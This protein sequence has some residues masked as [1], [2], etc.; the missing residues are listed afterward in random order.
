MNYVRFSLLGV[1]AFLFGTSASYSGELSALAE[2][3]ELVHF[4]DSEYAGKPAKLQQLQP[5]DL[6]RIHQAEKDMLAHQAVLMR[7]VENKENGWNIFA[8]GLMRSKNPE[9]TA[10]FIR[11]VQQNL[12][13]KEA[14]GSRMEFGFGAKNGCEEMSNDLG[15]VLAFYLGSIGD[16]RAVPTLREA[17]K[18]GDS[19][20]RDSAY[21]ALF[22]LGEYSFEEILDKLGE[23][24]FWEDAGVTVT[25]PD[26]PSPNT[27]MA[28]IED[29]RSR[30]SERAIGLYDQI[31]G[32]FP[33]RSPEVARAHFSKILCYEDLKKHDL[34]LRQCEV[35][36]QKVKLQDY[37][38]RI[39][40]I[41]NRITKLAQQD[42]ADQ[43]ATAPESKS[44]GNEKPNP[45]S[46]V[47]PQ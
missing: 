3:A 10:F 34:A 41:R 26:G 36:L 43:P 6:E 46:E 15:S 38:K 11:L 18:Q 8:Y 14:D 2:A 4:F 21:R 39:P 37:T 47:R 23:L 20:V 7:A 9:V 42:G 5:E 31:I 22:R 19:A 35:A 28:I 1:V 25:N 40:K 29:V 27:V 13:L 33:A 17:V 44:E 16:K 30:D 45:E 12:Y 24:S 32:K